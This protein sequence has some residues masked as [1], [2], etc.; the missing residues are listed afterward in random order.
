MSSHASNRI[1][2]TNQFQSPRPSAAQ[3]RAGYP[4]AVQAVVDA[5]R[6][7]FLELD[8]VTEDIAWHGVPWRWT[9]VYQTPMD[10]PQTVG[11]SHVTRA[12]GYLIP[13]P[14]RLQVCVPLSKEQV[15]VIPVGRIRKSLRDT[16]VFARTVAGVSWPTWE[17]SCKADLEEL[18]E[19]AS[20]KHRSQALA[21]SS[22][23]RV[24]ASA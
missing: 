5:S 6:E 18:A 2:W 9:L 7:V 12:F 8:G 21:R 3:L 23:L 19:L 13:D 10:D 14:A 1:V 22:K 11:A 20:L 16:I 24:Q 15:A 17:I 4:K